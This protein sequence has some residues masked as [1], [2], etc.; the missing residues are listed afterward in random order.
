M[1]RRENF[2]F[3]LQY[4]KSFSLAQVTVRA[5]LSAGCVSISI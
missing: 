2:A 1:N 4:I 5:L 3:L